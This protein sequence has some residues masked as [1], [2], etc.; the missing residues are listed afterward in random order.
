MQKKK[1]YRFKTWSHYHVYFSI[2][3]WL[4]E[5]TIAWLAWKLM[6]IL[7]LGYNFKYTYNRNSITKPYNMA[8]EN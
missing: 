3:D 8:L 6:I 5:T 4:L 2:I 1:E 7:F